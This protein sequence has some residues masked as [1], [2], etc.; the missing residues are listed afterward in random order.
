[1]RCVRQPDSRRTRKNPIRT[2][3]TT[4]IAKAHGA[5]AGI[6]VANPPTMPV[7]VG[8]GDAV[9]V[10]GTGVFVGVGG[11][12]VGVVVTVAVGV[13]ST[14][15]FVGVGGI[16]VVVAVA[17]G[18][19][20]GGGGVGVAVGVTWAKMKDEGKIT[21]ATTMAIRFL[22]MYSCNREFFYGYESQYR[23]HRADCKVLEEDNDSGSAVFT[24]IESWE[25]VL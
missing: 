25:F 7:G 9:G 16:G 18:V 10:G 12:D 17:V 15:V 3:E 6:G 2:S 21:A 22:G 14:G 23:T 24:D 4:N 8:L 19:G 13:G 11:T 1:M 5:S 20:V